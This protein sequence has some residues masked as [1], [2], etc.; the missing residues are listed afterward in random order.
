MRL[1]KSI[2]WRS[3]EH[4]GLENSA[5]AGGDGCALPSWVRPAIG[6][7]GVFYEISLTPEWVFESMSC[8]SAPTGVMTG[9]QPRQAWASGST[10][11]VDRTASTSTAAS[12]SISR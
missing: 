11:Q 7:D 4:G 10:R 6:V 12:T 8:R 1:R 3:F 9:A 5:F 2:R